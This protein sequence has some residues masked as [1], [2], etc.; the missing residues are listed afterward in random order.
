MTKN[1]LMM[2]ACKMVHLRYRF[3][4][5][6]FFFWNV[7]LARFLILIK[8]GGLSQLKFGVGVNIYLWAQKLE[9]FFMYHSQIC[10]ACYKWSVLG[11]Q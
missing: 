11:V 2:N 10:H 1:N 7:F 8:N 5:S 9:K 6:L 3:A 4:K